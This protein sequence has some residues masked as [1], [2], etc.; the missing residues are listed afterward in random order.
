MTLNHKIIS[1][2]LPICF[3]S[4]V[5]EHLGDIEK[6]AGSNPAGNTKLF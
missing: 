3:R 5:G 1:K 6:V 2:I 4:L